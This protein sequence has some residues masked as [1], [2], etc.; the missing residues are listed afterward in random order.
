VQRGTPTIGI[1]VEVHADENTA[2]ERDVK[3]QKMS[4]IDKVRRNQVAECEFADSGKD[5]GG[6]R[7]K[8]K[9]QRLRRK[10]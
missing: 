1:L 7:Q 2:T 3:V 5:D 8:T 4:R 9:G 6:N 10:N